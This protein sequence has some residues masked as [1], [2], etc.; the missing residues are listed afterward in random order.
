LPGLKSWDH[1][2]AGVKATIEGPV[3]RLV[4]T[5]SLT[6]NNTKLAGFNLPSRMSAIEKL[7]GIKGGSDT[8][9]QEFSGNVKVAP[10]GMTADAIKLILPAIGELGGG[11][12]VGSDNS[13]N[14]KMQATVHTGGV[15]KI[16]NNEPVPF[17]VE[18]TCAE[19]VFHPDLKAVV[20]EEVKG[21]GKAAGGLLKGL[22]GGKKP[23]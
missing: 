14:F 22:L 5:G 12:T 2:T 6:L 21:V 15:A 19:P 17:T 3:N 4:T 20:K 13:L 8:E 16:V 9:I 11:G 7:A 1:Y 18:G 10:E 23:N